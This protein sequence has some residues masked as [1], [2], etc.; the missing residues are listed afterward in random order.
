LSFPNI[1]NFVARKVPICLNGSKYKAVGAGVSEENDGA[2]ALVS[3]NPDTAGLAI[4]LAME[5]ARADSFHRAKVDAFFDKQIHLAGIQEHHL[6]EQFKQLRLTIWEKRMGVLLRVAT[7]FIGLAVAT[8]FAVMLW[9]ASHST[10]LLIEPFAV[11]P[12]MAARGMTGEVIANRLLDRLTDMQAQTM[13]RR[14]P[15]SYAS[16]WGRQGIK[17]DIPETGLSLT[18]VDGFLRN[19]LGQETHVTGDIVRTDTGIMM[20]ARA[21]D[22]SSAS[23]SGAEAN[24]E[25]LIQQAAE[26]IY[27]KTQPYRYAVYV[28]GQGRILEAIAVFK[29]L[30][31]PTAPPIEQQFALNALG[32]Q[33]EISDGI[34]AAIALFQKSLS[35]A[36]A[37]A[38]VYSNFAQ[39]LVYKGQTERALPYFETGVNRLGGAY[40]G[41]VRADIVPFIRLG[42]QAQLD[43]VAGAFH[44]AAAKE[45]Q[46][47]SRDFG[48]L[49]AGVDLARSL[50]GEHDISAAR[51]ALA[52]NAGAG[53]Y[54]E[55]AQFQQLEVR[56]VVDAAAQDWKRI[57]SRLVAVETL[58]RQ[59]PGFRSIVPTTIMPL[60]AL[61]QAHLGEFAAAEKTIVAT[62]SDCDLCLLARGQIANLQGRQALAGSWFAR[63]LAHAP[64]LPFAETEWGEA[65]LT[66]G[67]SEAA[68]EK[69]QLASKKG[70]HFADPLEG[71]GEALMAKNQSHLA[72]PKFAEAEKYA[73]NWGRLHLKW[74]EALVWAGK[75][76]EA[77]AQFARAATL[78]L[79]PAE[80]QEL[81]KVH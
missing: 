38:V 17:V 81:A 31:V 42:Y 12:D 4:D 77:K 69:F 20:T 26:S 23:L 44:D 37:Y 79:T 13:T 10:A 67:K 3:G 9:Q 39:A 75:A 30:A 43:R 56:F 52:D 18:E 58:T 49:A 70:P 65:L 55:I 28:R 2:D 11:P 61:A 27:R 48:I 54:K 57:P 8:G 29:T 14:S 7:A 60:V 68:I 21:G 62:S 74:G 25:G 16:D 47:I 35:S 24:L 80:K 34:D 22:S 71:W 46:A 63:A 53:F 59:Y 64:T 51:A 1:G 41:A 5:E 6:R 76:D 50:A 40:E 15:R 36:D 33:A 32:L 19:K 78:D 73:P 66:R 72:L 45:A